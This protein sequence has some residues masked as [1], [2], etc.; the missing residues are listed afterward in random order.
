MPANILMPALSPSMDKGN[1][2]NWLK[3][4]GDRVKIGDILAEIETDKATMEY[5]SP[6]EGVLAKIFVPAGSADILVHTTIAVLAIDG[7]DVSAVAA[8]AGNASAGPSAKVSASPFSSPQTVRAV[9]NIEVAARTGQEVA[10]QSLM[11]KCVAIAPTAGSGPGRTLS[12]PLVRRLAREAGVELSGLRGSGPHGRVIAQDVA[13]AKLGQGSHP[14]D[15]RPADNPVATVPSDEQ[16]R[17]LFAEGSYK[18]E[19]HDNMRKIIARR[20]T[21]S[22]Q[23]V[24]HFYLSVDCTLE[25]LMA[26][27]SEFNAAAPKHENG[28]PVYKLSINDFA[29]KALAVALQRLPDA[30]VTW[31]ESSMLKHIHSDIGVAVAIPGGL[32][33]PVVRRVEVKSLSAISKEMKDLAARARARKLAPN[34]Y[35]GS[36]AAISNLG[37]YGIKD[38]AAVI[39]PPDATILAVGASE[40]RAVVREGKLAVG[41]LMTVTLSTDHRAVDGALAAELIEAFKGLIENPLTMIV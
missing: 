21:V 17:G 35:Q 10:L 15:R 34:E 8:S 31:T 12:S 9:E 23:T 24:P 33:T 11:G 27:R 39:N 16:I 20:L 5:G 19:P 14:T 38:F 3:K 7:E 4:E 26:T 36:A 37:M 6:N 1:I 41:H 2:A 22:K 32:I 25:K 40:E 18:L 29:I 28:L 13:A 30:N